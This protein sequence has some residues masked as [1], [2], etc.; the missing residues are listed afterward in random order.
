MA[1]PI[2]EVF[3]IVHLEDDQK[4]RNEFKRVFP[5][6]ETRL[7]K[8]FFD[9]FSF[10]N[11]IP[12][13]PDFTPML[14]FKL[15]QFK[16]IRDFLDGIYPENQLTETSSK[17]LFFVMDYVI[18]R[19]DLVMENLPIA[20]VAGMN[21][22][23]WLDSIFPHIPVILLANEDESEDVP[24]RW[25]VIPQD[26]F[27]NM[28]EL[29]KEF[30]LYFNEWWGASFWREL[31][32]YAFEEGSKS[33]HTPGHNGGNAFLR[34]QF[35][36]AF[37]YTF[38]H[39]I[40]ETDLSVSVD[41]LGDL[42]EPD[43]RSRDYD[44]PGLKP[45]Q[46]SQIRAANI[47]GAENTFYMT[48]G[49]SS[50]NKAM[51]M[52]LLHPGEVVL[53]D[54]NCHKSVH[55]AVVMSGAL[56]LYLEP[57]Y[58]EA[59]GVWTP[60]DLPTLQSFITRDYPES[61]KPR[62][63]ILTTCTY[64]GVLYP[65]HRI[66]KLCEEYGIVFYA[67]EA[68]APYLRFHPYYTA[69]DT[70]RE[71]DGTENQFITRYNGCDAGAHFTVQSTHKA[72]AAFSQASMIHISSSFRALLERDQSPQWDWL[73]ER[74]SFRGKG[75]YEKFCH[76]LVENL[77]Y[78]HSTSP[79]YPMLATL[80]M[81][82]LQMRL[83]GLSLLEKRHR[84]IQKFKQDLAQISPDSVVNL[85]DIIGDENVDRYPG[86]MKDPL[87]LIIGVQDEECG[88][89]LKK[90][91][92]REH[93]QWEKSSR[94]CIE[95]LITIGT[96]NDHLQKLFEIINKNRDLL[97]Y[98]DIPLNYDGES[99][100]FNREI[101]RSRTLILPMDAASCDGE[102]VALGESTGRIGAQMLVPYPPGI[103]V[104]L[105]GLQIT[106][107]VVDYVRS[108]I[109][110]GLGGSIHGLFTDRGKHFVK[111]MRKKEVDVSWARIETYRNYIKEQGL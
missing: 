29:S 79:N 6:I 25:G 15:V 50:S 43:Y 94:G 12:G 54:R 72:L 93:I 78:W 92:E 52:T 45:L 73:R 20:K 87:K 99:V 39:A 49:T 109:S 4:D 31:R 9:H 14:E 57:E 18:Q 38:D 91:L 36:K 86:Y 63:L 42:S 96:Y 27:S 44:Q 47:F 17:I 85:I 48:N 66:A 60:V 100:E 40:F 10:K 103:P 46:R 71:A 111:V 101:A 97:G 82:G 5:W 28:T 65:I 3:Y 69:K 53:L 41:R 19:E 90:I 102:L 76:D 30:N 59:L 22:A 108:L 62:M 104:I 33:W 7:N 98:P 56:P 106:Q 75:S 16:S 67:D 110:Q 77:R 32:H 105:P 107:S 95:F 74:N 13:R 89:E 1:E 58:N 8:F 11:I 83:E 84:W 70:Y 81:A 23:D 2:K 26:I 35:Q 51:L 88:D 34:S 80:D 24:E 61:L 37:Y 55:Q 21:F 64:E 68:W